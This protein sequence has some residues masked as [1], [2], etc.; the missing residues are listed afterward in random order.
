MGFRMTMA[1]RSICEDRK[2]DDTY[3]DTPDQYDRR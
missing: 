2:R 3:L 1:I